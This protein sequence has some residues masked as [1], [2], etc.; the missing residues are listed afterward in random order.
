MSADTDTDADVPEEAWVGSGAHSKQYVY[1]TD[2][3]C[4]AMP[5]EEHRRPLAPNEAVSRDLSECKLCA[6]KQQAPDPSPTETC[7]WCGVEEVLRYHLPCPEA[8][9]GE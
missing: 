1:H 4:T 7:P 5:A 2:A 8:G 6:D 3:D 9:G